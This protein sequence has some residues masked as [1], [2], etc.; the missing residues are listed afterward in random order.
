M[1]NNS[2]IAVAFTK[3]K[4]YGDKEVKARELEYAIYNGATLISSTRSP[5]KALKPGE[6]TNVE[7][8]VNINNVESGQQK[9]PNCI[10]RYSR[11]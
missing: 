11:W 5:I 3:V 2:G 4:N 8:A 1:R 7:V 10:P 9:R 6:E